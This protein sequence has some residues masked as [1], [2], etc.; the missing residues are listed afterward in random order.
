MPSDVQV[1]RPLYDSLINAAQTLVTV[2]VKMGTVL[3]EEFEQAVNEPASALQTIID[4]CPAVGESFDGSFHDDDA[5]IQAEYFRHDSQP[6][7]SGPPWGVR[8]TYR[9]TGQTVE[10]YSKP[11]REENRRS[12]TKGLRT[13]VERRAAE[14]R[15][16]GSL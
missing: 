15:R 6:Q 4:Q 8:L 11:S 16:A 3:S 14:L 1:P 9:P 12:A 10:S 7:A 13:L 5:H 2:T